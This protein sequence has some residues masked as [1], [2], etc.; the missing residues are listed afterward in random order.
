MG[1]V[2]PKN[3][4][5]VP[6]LMAM[7]CINQCGPRCGLKLGKCC[8]TR[9]GVNYTK[10]SKQKQTLCEEVYKCSVLASVEVVLHHLSL[11]EPQLRHVVAAVV[12]KQHPSARLQVTVQLSDHVAHPADTTTPK[13]IQSCGFLMSRL[14][15]LQY[16]LLSNVR[17]TNLLGL[18]A[19]STKMRVTM[20]R[21]PGAKGASQSSAV[22]S[23]T[24]AWHL[25]THILYFKHC[26][27]IS[28]RNVHSPNQSS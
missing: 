17:S 11:F 24:N 19:D 10:P 26:I 21:L 16:N 2:T 5:T 28:Q 23:H 3:K 7:L 4:T 25:H 12:S 15:A 14:Q 6:A 20:S 18:I 8:S 9:P 1:L 22:T 13:I 27:T